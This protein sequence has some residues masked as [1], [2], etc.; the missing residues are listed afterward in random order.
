MV[1]KRWFG[2]HSGFEHGV[3]GWSCSG[4]H[5]PEMYDPSGANQLHFWH[6]ASLVALHFRAANVCGTVS[7][8]YPC[9]LYT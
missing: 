4:V 1:S 6:T 2:G 8:M 7:V 9:A 3:C 5:I